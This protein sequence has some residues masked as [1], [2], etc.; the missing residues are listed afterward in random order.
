MKKSMF[1]KFWQALVL[2]LLLVTV[3]PQGALAADDKIAHTVNEDGSINPI[4]NLKDLMDASRKTIVYLDQ[5][6]VSYNQ[7][8]NDR[9]SV[10]IVEGT[11]SR[12]NLNGHT[13]MRKDNGSGS[14]G[15]PIFWLNPNSTLILYG[16]KEYTSFKDS[17]G[18][19][20]VKSGG[21]V[22]SER[23]YK[24]GAFRFNE[25]AK[26][27]MYDVAV[28]GN[29]TTNDGGAIYVGESDCS[30]EMYNTKIVKNKS[31]GSGIVYIDGSNC[32]IYME[33]STISNNEGTGIYINDDNATIQMEKDSS[34]S[35]NGTRGIYANYSWF[36]IISE[37]KTAVISG[38]NN[39]N[40][41]GTGIYVNSRTFGSNWG[42][43]SGITFKDN[44]S[45]FAGGLYL[46]QNNTTVSDCTFENNSSLR[47]GGAIYSGGK[48]TIENCT[49]INNTAG[50]NGGGIYST[51]AYDIT[52]RGNL[53][54]KNNTGNGSS[55]DVYLLS[56]SLMKSYILADNID[57]NSQIGIK[58]DTSGDRLL[59]KNLSSF[60]YGNTFFLDESSSYHIGFQ[61]N[62]KELWQRS[63]STN[64]AVTV[65]GKEFGRYNVGDTVTVTDNN[66]SDYQVFKNWTVANN[67]IEI[68][69]KD[70]LSKTFSFKMPALNVDLNA[71]YNYYATKMVLDVN[72][73]TVDKGFA[74]EGT[75]TYYVGSEKKEETVNLKWYRRI[76]YTNSS[77]EIAYQYSAFDCT[78]KTP[79]SG[80]AYAILAYIYKDKEEGLWFSPKTNTSDVEVSFGDNLY[81][82]KA[83]RIRV[84][85]RGNMEILSDAV[86]TGKDTIGSITDSLS[87]TIYG[88]KSS[89]ELTYLINNYIYKTLD[90]SVTA[91]S[92]N[93]KTYK[94]NV[95]QFKKNQIEQ[96]FAFENGKAKNG[97]YNLTL[98]LNEGYAKNVK[99]VDLNGHTSVNFP[100][101]IA[102]N[103]ASYGG[104]VVI[105]AKDGD[106]WQSVIDQIPSSV[107]VIA[108]DGN[109]Y[110]VDV[111]KVSIGDQLDSIFD[112]KT[113][114]KFGDNQ[115]A[116][117][118][119]NFSKP[120]SLDIDISDARIKV[121]VMEGSES[122][123][124]N[125]IK[126]TLPGFGGLFSLASENEIM[127]TSEDDIMVADEDYSNQSSDYYFDVDGNLHIVIRSGEGTT[128]SYK[129]DDGE[130]IVTDSNS[131][132][133]RLSDSNNEYT[134]TAW[135]NKDGQKSE[136]SIV[137]YQLCGKQDD[138]LETPLFETEE[139][140]YTANNENV[141]VDGD[142]IKLT[143]KFKSGKN[144]KYIIAKND[145]VYDENNLTSYNENEGIV[146]E[147]SKDEID[148]Y[149]ILAYSTNGTN[150]SIGAIGTFVL[151][152]SEEAFEEDETIELDVSIDT[153]VAGQ[154]LPG[155]LKVLINDEEDI[156]F[157]DITYPYDNDSVAQ[158][159]T[160]Y[161]AE[162]NLGSI[163]KYGITDDGTITDEDKNQYL[164]G[165]V[166]VN[167]KN[168]DN[169]E[170]VGWLDI[171]S[172]NLILNILFPM[173]ECEE[174]IY[175]L[176]K[177]GE[178][179]Y[180]NISYET[181]LKLNEVTY[182]KDEGYTI[183]DNYNLPSRV[184]VTLDDG[185]VDVV[186]IVWNKEFEKGF[187]P[188]N[189][190][191]QQLV[192]KG[193]LDIPGYIKNPNGL[194]TTITLT[195]NVMGK[196]SHENKVV[197]CEEA[198]NSK[199]WSW[200]ES[201]KACVYRVSNTSS[202]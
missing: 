124:L 136:A 36:K 142:K 179:T 163:S 79:Q 152:N 17:N 178:L 42:K 107:N 74:T 20:I 201:K 52:L 192:I 101:T 99:G 5:D 197:T 29:N 60:D 40:V 41:T 85:M 98:T 69:D 77:G 82:N 97:T 24:G 196:D 149:N 113:T 10:Q 186:N 103:T 2:G 139:G 130:E 95:L 147:T 141:T 38:H 58:S 160:S 194:D 37:D 49:I 134:V 51:Q 188:N 80:T 14:E 72:Y 28:A 21:L 70:K 165:D 115:S 22:Y 183:A 195:I 191:A 50:G 145:D 81:K 171:E 156:I 43:I 89:D 102:S 18:N 23:S 153:P 94:L 45:Y 112:N 162:V 114:V 33:N 68:N 193:T 182:G 133:V 200:S 128:I 187:D 175:N 1:F 48:N 166:I 47:D 120:D 75:L 185:S 46:N 25:G 6:V 65:N 9:S 66:T 190:N 117:A 132:D 181:A 167:F 8:V 154:K 4:Y 109:S 146:L 170:I 144:I 158:Y 84:D 19:E 11:T 32:K 96:A 129:I 57:V 123:L 106:T 35:N 173:T 92:A 30:I 127:L 137:T 34:I 169:E 131:C 13:F 116:T 83:V 88:S 104:G 15:A 108:K 126:P 44:K 180:D 39:T 172:G 199:N 100:V 184:S 12:I 138:R 122:D 93:N 111:N 159:G 148:I 202:K 54:I 61:S 90:D 3:I 118:Y 176:I 168:N 119:L 53:T 110:S 16:A 135:A 73:P 55:D 174:L 155:E 71:E 7:Y 56:S 87:L 143:V 59:V 157:T 151:V 125:L 76:P 198:M 86:V 189:S 164:V 27:I 161:I 150:K 63:G 67:T 78:T 105:F 177:I 64:Y 121:T 91:V 140:I 26:L 62:S 31:G